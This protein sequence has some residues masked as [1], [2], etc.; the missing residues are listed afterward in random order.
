ML[1]PQLPTTDW[2]IE[3]DS[4]LESGGAFSQTYYAQVYPDEVNDRLKLINQL[5]AFN[6]V[7]LLTQTAS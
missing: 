2:V 3:C 5:E 1:L 7:I 4:T 6:L